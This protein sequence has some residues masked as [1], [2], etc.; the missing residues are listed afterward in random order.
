[1]IPDIIMKLTAILLLAQGVYSLPANGLEVLESLPE[2]PSTWK[3]V[4]T[5]SPDT[6]LLLRIALH[7]VSLVCFLGPQLCAKAST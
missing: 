1:M 3:Q 7:H 4:A 6:R 5:P 2:A